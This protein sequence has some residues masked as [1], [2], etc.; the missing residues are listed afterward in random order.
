MSDIYGRD[1][2]DDEVESIKKIIEGE[3]YEAVM[4]D[5]AEVRQ[6]SYEKFYEWYGK[7]TGKTVHEMNEELIMTGIES[8][9]QMVKPE[10]KCKTLNDVHKDFSRE[11]SMSFIDTLGA[12]QD[13]GMKVI[14]ENHG[15]ASAVDFLEG[16]G[17]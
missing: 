14:L 13:R 5:V 4:K 9:N 11:I 12:M 10:A 16:V 17:H 15:Y 1:L 2:D 6:K 3:G 7:K 8:Y